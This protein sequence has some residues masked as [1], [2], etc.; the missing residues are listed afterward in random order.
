MSF[1]SLSSSS[2]FAKQQREN[3][4]IQHNTIPI[5]LTSIF[6]NFHLLKRARARKRM[7]ACAHTP[8]CSFAYIFSCNGRRKLY[9]VERRNKEKSTTAT[10]TT[11]LCL[12][13]LSVCLLDRLNAIS[14]HERQQTL[15]LFHVTKDEGSIN[16]IINY[17]ARFERRRQQH[18]K[19]N[20]LQR[21]RFAEGLTGRI[22]YRRYLCSMRLQCKNSVVANYYYQFNE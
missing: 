13:R 22:D 18:K 14:I 7:I 9:L 2:L 10:A 15:E 20:F 21:Q 16:T 17:S 6:V 12:Q 11:L 5:R 1:F 3:S 4:E 8:D 19:L